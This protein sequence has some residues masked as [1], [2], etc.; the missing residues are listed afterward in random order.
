LNPNA[1]AASRCHR[2]SS[3]WAQV[4]QTAEYCLADAP[5]LAL[6]LIFVS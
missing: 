2:P 1:A 4:A 6:P 5:P 3:S